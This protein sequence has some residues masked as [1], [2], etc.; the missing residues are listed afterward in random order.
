M[1]IHLA[2]LDKSASQS[3]AKSKSFLSPSSSSNLK[4]QSNAINKLKSSFYF[5]LL[6]LC[7][8]YEICVYYL[9]NDDIRLVNASLE[10]L[11]VLLKLAPFRFASY[12]TKTGH[13]NQ[14]FLQIKRKSKMTNSMDSLSTLKL[15][16]S[17]TEE[18]SQPIKSIC[19]QI[20]SFYD[21]ENPPA[22][23]LIRLLAY[24]FLLS[25]N[26]PGTKLKS[27]GEVKI[28][29]KASALD[30][31]SSIL[32]LCPQLIFKT[33]F[34][35]SSYPHDLYIS[36]LIEYIN[37]AE[38]KMRT[39]ASIL[40]GQLINSILLNK[41]GDFDS[42]LAKYA[43]K[44]SLEKQF[45]Y[46][47]LEILVDYLMR[48]IRSENNKQ[49]NNIC[50]RFALS[51]LRSFLPTLVKTHH[52]SY[53]LEILINLI[54]LKHSTYNL[55]KCELVD[56]LASIDF[57]SVCY[58]EQELG[59]KS[60][61]ED[62]DDEINSNPF[63]VRN[64]Q[65]RIIE[66][67]FL[68]LLGSEDSKVRLET[69]RSLTRFVLNMN[70]YEVSSIQNQNL[71]LA[72]G[73]HSLKSD[74]YAPNFLNSSLIDN[75][76]HNLG[77]IN[78]LFDKT[79]SNQTQATSV[80]SSTS[81]VTP[82]S[83]LHGSSTNSKRQ[84][85]YSCSPLS[86]VSFNSSLPWLS[87]TNQILLNN[88]IQPF[89]SLIKYWPTR[90]SNTGILNNN[91]NKIVEHNLAYLVP[92]LVKSLIE[93]IDKYQF[94]GCLE[95]L[96]FIFQTYQPAL[97]YSNDQQLIDL[98]NL[99]IN[100]LKHSN[101]SF[102]LY[103]HDIVTRL[104]GNLFSA[105]S[106]LNMK[107]LDKK[108]QQL[109]FNL[110]NSTNQNIP[111]IQSSIESLNSSIKTIPFAQS[112]AELSTGLN[113]TYSF[114]F[115][116]QQIKPCI[117]QLFV[118]VMKMLCVLACVIDESSL[119]SNLTTNLSAGST[120][121]T[122]PPPPTPAPSLAQPEQATNIPQTPTSPTNPGSA[123]PSFIRAK[124]SNLTDPKLIK[125]S[126]NSSLSSGSTT[127]TAQTANSKE[128]EAPTSLPKT[129]NNIYLGFFQNSSHYLKLYELIRTSYN[130]YK[131]SSSI[132]TYDRFTQIIKT[133][134]NLLAQLLEA[135]LSVHEIG[136][137][138]DEILL[139]LRII[140]TIEPSCS[141]KCV[142]L[143]LK[144]L[145]SLNLAGLMFE[146]I[147]QQVT[148]AQASPTPNSSTLQL[149]VPISGLSSVISTSMTSLTSFNQPSAFN[150]LN[151]WSTNSKRQQTSLFSSLI[152]NNLAQF[153]RF[154][155]YY[156]FKLLRE[157]FKWFK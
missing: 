10:C 26:E 109:N 14:T 100:Y 76:A 23:Y 142:T 27:D 89:H 101:V 41:S 60:V 98:L 70:F 50:K 71:L 117:D 45:K 110:N 53:S 67:V 74:G 154:I 88:F 84:I 17:I 64:T 116:N 139:Y 143:C 137:H 28:L 148:R 130:S 39:N 95:T 4:P 75:D 77:S 121:V 25:S 57:K 87:K 85:K 146:Y 112:L 13:S 35:D 149:P 78:N 157:K 111:L 134:L 113:Y 32:S 153:T 129:T 31:C 30:C 131:K 128:P 145:F 123:S 79:K 118:H 29:V 62:S 114:S 46:F 43:G 49:T 126:S 119:P 7:Q 15:E 81:F 108:I 105:F 156:K 73:E 135:S 132:N 120:A 136:P 2:E 3:S 122:A 40:I 34:L 127:N 47:K 6:N 106:W 102:D 22:L 9:N 48:F 63:V 12:L 20:G 144:S 90:A 66:E 93:S 11:Q 52:S 96:D 24:K 103:A 68:Y 61:Q 65:E 36:D 94:L 18:E 104:I 133:T 97:Y 72:A 86:A 42:W 152:Q 37:H 55:V 150:Q 51:S 54:H 69:A 80:T 44:E 83:I 141:V 33:L 91:L 8:V 151:T 16:D 58:V 155:F 124:F 125:N 115:N 5:N 107:K 59:S 147:Q 1:I 19:D 92:I 99:F 56:L 21:P 140:F 38:N 138:L 82:A